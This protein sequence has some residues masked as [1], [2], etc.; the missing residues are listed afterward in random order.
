MVQGSQARAP[1][2]QV[3]P[4]GEEWQSA[5][6]AAQLEAVVGKYRKLWEPSPDREAL[7]TIAVPALLLDTELFDHTCSTASFLGASRAFPWK[8]ASSYDGF[9]PRHFSLLQPRGRH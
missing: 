1:P 9:H 3:Q 5:L 7:A 6:P 2:N 4:E 8:T